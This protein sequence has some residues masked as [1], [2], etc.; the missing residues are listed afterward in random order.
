MARFLIALHRSEAT[1]Q[2]WAHAQTIGFRG[3]DYAKARLWGLCELRPNDDTAKRTSGFWRLTVGGQAFI[4]MM[5]RV[6]THACMYDS[7]LVGFREETLTIK[8]ALASG[9]FDYA[10]MMGTV[11]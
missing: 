2:E 1:G 11:T 3:G 10:Q 9:G 8:D 7:D 6:P 4:A 5:A